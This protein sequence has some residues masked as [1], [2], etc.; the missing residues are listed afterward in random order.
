MEERRKTLPEDGR[1]PN[2]VYEDLRIELRSGPA[3]TL[4][5]RYDRGVNWWVGTTS[6]YKSELRPA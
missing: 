5:W 1:E 6:E 3:P 4:A 2:P